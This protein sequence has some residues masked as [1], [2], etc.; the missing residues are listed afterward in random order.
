MT[1]ANQDRSQTIRLAV[2]GHIHL[3]A[4]TGPL[5]AAAVKDYLR[6]F[7]ARNLTGICCLAPGA[8]TIFATAVLDHGGRLEVVLPFSD[9]RETKLEAA[10]QPIFDSLV[11]RADRVTTLAGDLSDV[12]A[13]YEQANRELL[14][15][16]D[17]LVAIWD[18]RCSDKQGSTGAL[19][20]QAECPVDRIW[21]PGAGR[22]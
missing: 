13:S 20:A 5:V 15:R 8:D 17:R 21:P 6:G 16:C 14:R 19:V 2:T 11:A 1:S 18:G 7:D 3:T 12:Q 22:S 4:A 9:Y 10:R